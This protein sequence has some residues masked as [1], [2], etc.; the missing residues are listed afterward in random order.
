MNTL[1]I[2]LIAGLFYA[3]VRGIHNRHLAKRLELR[4][5]S[6]RNALR[7][8]V[9]TGKVP[10]SSPAYQ[11]MDE[12]FGEAALESKDVSGW[13]FVYFWM[14]RKRKKRFMAGAGKDIVADFNS[15]PILKEFNQEFKYIITDHLL[16]RHVIVTVFIAILSI[17]PLAIFRMSKDTIRKW[18][19]N[20][21]EAG[22][23]IQ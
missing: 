22:A 20:K 2:I 15:N 3:L 5:H 8:Q 10:A 13:S 9:I 6:L 17:L 11:S 1:E 16:R 4:I 18:M 7:Y 23:M 14:A 19:Q 21:V 12:A